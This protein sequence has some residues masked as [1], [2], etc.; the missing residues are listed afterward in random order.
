MYCMETEFAFF[1]SSFVKKT[2][3]MPTL[4]ECLLESIAQYDAAPSIADRKEAAVVVVE[5]VRMYL[6]AEDQTP[7]KLKRLSDLEDGDTY[8]SNPNT[9][10]KLQVHTT[11]RR[12][13]T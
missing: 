9:S 8:S 2:I 6:A 11:G 5:R 4:R 12:P 3:T 7:R 1:G 10:T 13:F